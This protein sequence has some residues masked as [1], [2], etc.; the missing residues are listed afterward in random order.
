VA[1]SRLAHSSVRGIPDMPCPGTCRVNVDLPI[2]SGLNDHMAEDT[3]RQRTSA[4][5]A[6]T[7]E[8]NAYRL[9][10]FGYHELYT[11][12]FLLIAGR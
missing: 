5:I 12:V 11:L 6:K 1:F 7:H 3:L 4:D 2:V 9:G 10:A 8:E